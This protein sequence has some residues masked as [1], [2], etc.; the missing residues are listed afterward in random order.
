[1]NISHVLTETGRSLL[2]ALLA[3]LLATS[4]QW[5]IAYEACGEAIGENAAGGGAAYGIAL[6]GTAIIVIVWSVFFELVLRLLKMHDVYRLLF[7]LFPSIFV[8]I[9]TARNFS[10]LC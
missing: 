4:F 6:L 5:N 8:A 10:G 9:T 1:M 3:A 2:L 7:L